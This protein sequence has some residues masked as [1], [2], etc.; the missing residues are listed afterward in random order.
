MFCS[1][2]DCLHSRLDC[3]W[4]SFRSSLSH[5][6]YITICSA[7]C[8]CEYRLCLCYT[9]FSGKAHSWWMAPTS[10][11]AILSLFYYYYYFECSYSHYLQ[12][13][14]SLFFA[15]CLSARLTPNFE[16]CQWMGIV[17]GKTMIGSLISN[18]KATQD[19]GYCLYF[20]SHFCPYCSPLDKWLA[21]HLFWS[22]RGWAGWLPFGRGRKVIFSQG[23]ICRWGLGYG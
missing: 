15:C 11:F 12:I 3:Y 8:R 7:R 17:N 10:I 20:N 2:F 18:K 13:W 1:N 14:I 23:C 21:M 16:I 5:I 4:F 22:A 19:F 9:C 6:A